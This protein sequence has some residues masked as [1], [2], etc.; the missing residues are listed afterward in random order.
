MFEP[1]NLVLFFHPRSSPKKKNKDLNS[2][3]ITIV[4][5][6]LCGPA[7]ST[8]LEKSQNR[9]HCLCCLS[10]RLLYNGR[11]LQLFPPQLLMESVDR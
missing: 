4:S 2:F 5:N 7:E 11:L 9:V 10:E 3:V 6:S 1:Q 8:I